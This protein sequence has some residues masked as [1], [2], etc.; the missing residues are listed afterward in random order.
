M[1]FD[2]LKSFYIL[3]SVQNRP[4][5]ALRSTA[6]EQKLLLLQEL[7]TL[8]KSWPKQSGNIVVSRMGSSPKAHCWGTNRCPQKIVRFLV[9]NCETLRFHMKS[10]SLIT[11]TS[12]LPLRYLSDTSPIPLRYLSISWGVCCWN[13]SQS[14][15]AAPNLGVSR[16]RLCRAFC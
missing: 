15:F 4:F 10:P 12:P 11:A 6:H 2:I 16:P 14:L 1:H 8:L 13:Q 7:L 3:P 5:F 9:F